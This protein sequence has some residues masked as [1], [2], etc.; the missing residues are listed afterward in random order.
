[1][2][3]DGPEWA[4]KLKREA[5]KEGFRVNMEKGD[6]QQGQQFRSKTQKH[7]VDPQTVA[8]PNVGQPTQI[9]VVALFK[10]VL[11]DQLFMAPLGLILFLTSMGLL[12]GLEWSGIAERF[13]RLYWALLIANW[14]M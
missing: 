14:Q 10:R 11:I 3:D 1:M 7:I 12:E 8:M 9:S 2:H 13:R 6:S 4:S 5:E